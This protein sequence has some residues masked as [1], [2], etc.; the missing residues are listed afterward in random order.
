[1][2]DEIDEQM[3]TWMIGVLEARYGRPLTER[4]LRAVYA[5]CWPLTQAEKADRLGSSD[6][7]TAA[8]IAAGYARVDEAEKAER[9]R[10][11]YGDR[12]KAGIPPH[13]AIFSE[14]V[15]TEAVAGSVPRKWSVP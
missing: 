14:P 4:E 3:G 5:S 12:T 9:E 10:G 2:T 15:D 8:V 13:V 6:F 11:M 1:M 7:D